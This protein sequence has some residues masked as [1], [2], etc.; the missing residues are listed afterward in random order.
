[1]GFVR[2]NRYFFSEGGMCTAWLYLP[3]GVEKPPAV[4]MAHGFSAERSFRLD[5]YAEKFAEAGLAVFVFDYRNFGDSPGTPRQLVDPGRHLADWKAALA[6][7]RSLPEVDGR[8]IALWG[9]SFSGGHVLATAAREAGEGEGVKAVV[10]QV[11]YVGGIEVK[12]P[13]FMKLKA[14]W[15]VLL[16]AV[17]ARFGGAHFIPAVGAPGRFGCM[18]AEEAEEFLALVPE[19]SGWK[20][21]VPARILTKLAAYQPREL[22]EKVT[23]PALIVVAEKDQLTPPDLAREM[24]GKMPRVAVASYEC[25]HFGVY[26]GAVFEDVAARE[27]DFLKQYLS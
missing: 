13:F 27:R 22:A 20:N 11:P 25:G 17:K 4:L 5:A 10:A 21:A 12:L 26:T 23:C 15:A 14:L 8:R 6:H 2:S 7:L 9:S 1:M 3:D 16:D 24:A 19:G 18:M